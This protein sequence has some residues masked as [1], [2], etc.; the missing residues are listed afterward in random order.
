MKL[1]GQTGVE[2]KNVM[3]K[4]DLGSVW[5]SAEVDNFLRLRLFL[6]AMFD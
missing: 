3:E 1:N 5:R 6:V 4:S 2:E